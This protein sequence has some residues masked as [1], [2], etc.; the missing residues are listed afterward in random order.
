M[1]PGE[2]EDLLHQQGV[3]LRS[4]G[5][6]FARV[7]DSFVKSLIASEMVARSIKGI[8]RKTMQD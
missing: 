3:T 6:I 2:L 8:F 1:S 4:L 7:S 5:E